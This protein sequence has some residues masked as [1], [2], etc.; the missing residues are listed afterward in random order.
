MRKVGPEPLAAFY[1]DMLL[2]QQHRDGNDP[3]VQALL[4]LSEAV[5]KNYTE[6]RRSLFAYLLKEC[7]EA[8]LAEMGLSEN[9]EHLD[10]K[11]F[12]LAMVLRC[13]IGAKAKIGTGGEVGPA[14][15]VYLVLDD[16]E[17]LLT[18]PGETAWAFTH[19]LEQ[20]SHDVGGGLTIWLNCKAT[21][22]ATIER[23]QKRFGRR[24]LREWITHTCFE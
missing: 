22:A 1:P 10:D 3:V 16:V 19:A 9:L 13:M 18:L 15:R 21:D 14:C 8:A 12:V 6:L 17:N 7:S 24:L 2:K 23:V 11:L 4:L 5:Q 20:L